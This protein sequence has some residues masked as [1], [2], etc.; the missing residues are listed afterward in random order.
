MAHILLVE[1]N[2]DNS[3]MLSRRLI[4]RGFEVEIAVDGE[5]CLEVAARRPPDLVLMDLGLPGIDGYETTRRL[6]TAPATRAVPVIALSAH[7]MEDH[8]HRAEEAGCDDFDEKPVEL[9]RL[10]RKMAALLPPGT[11]ASF[12]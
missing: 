1:D 6:K 2:E 4:K 11:V 5:T 10:L 8:R 9:S 7:T 3:D 12:D